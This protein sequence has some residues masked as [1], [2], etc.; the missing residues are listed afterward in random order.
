MHIADI[1]R[2]HTLKIAFALTGGFLMILQ[3]A[4]DAQFF[5][6][7]TSGNRNDITL[8]P[9][10]QSVNIDP[11][12]FTVSEIFHHS[13]P[14]A[15]ITYHGAG[16]T[17]QD[18]HPE[19]YISGWS[20]R[21]WN[22]DPPPPPSELTIFEANADDTVV[23]SP[24]L[25]G[26]TTTPGTTF[27]RVDDFDGDT[28]PD[29]LITGHNESPFA[30]TPNTIYLNR[31]DH[32]EPRNI[33]PAMAMHEG[34]LGDFDLDGD[35][36][37][38]ASAYWVDLVFS[39]GPSSAQSTTNDQA[40][41]V[42]FLNDGMS[43]FTAWPL[44]F[45]Q[46]IEGLDADRL[47][48]LEKMNSGSAAAFGNID[49][50][51]ENEIIVID[52]NLGPGGSGQPE[53]WIIDDI[54]FESRYIYGTFRPLPLPYLETNSRFANNPFIGVTVNPSHDVHVELLDID[55]DG[56]SDLVIDS[57]IWTEHP[58]DTAGVVQFL[59]NDGTGSFTDVTETTLYNYNLMNWGSHD[60]R[61]L[62]VNHDGFIDILKV[63]RG[64][65]ETV[66]K[67]W[68][69]GATMGS[70]QSAPNTWAND[71][72]INTGTGK[73]VSA[74]RD[75]FHILT[76]RQEQIFK[77]YGNE[78]IPY[79]L[80]DYPYYPYLLRD[81]RLG[82]ATFQEV[83]P[84]RRAITGDPPEQFWFDVRSKH[85]LSTGPYGQNTSSQG[86]PGYSEYFYLTE[87]PDVMTSIETGYYSTGLEHY[88][89]QGHAE[90]RKTFAPGAHVH[91][92]NDTDVIT[93][94]EG[95]EQ[96]FGYGGSDVFTGLAG[97]DLLDGGTGFDT[98]MFLGPRNNYDLQIEGGTLTVTALDTNEGT[99]TL[100]SIE[101]LRFTDAVICLH[102]TP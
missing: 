43:N 30:M 80:F 26:T 94:R 25:L 89:R 7:G 67:Q 6:E 8:N 68:P 100:K 66:T 49:T 65:M 71:I 40:A 70:L 93:L 83:T 45:N 62:D 42:L 48:G 59:E 34:Y 101:Y 10:P 16:D 74:F 15:V 31:G 1:L 86:A 35:V 53:S 32:F 5:R 95:D 85:L 54:A 60:P 44:R 3:T 20:W 23:L 28:R 12:F 4:N 72:L 58:Q 90:G 19:L 75:G 57:L 2:G 17:D 63:Q 11:D 33:S 50:D 91:G 21:G 55:N 84:L 78:F 79:S 73:F 92:H 56:D 64:V 99:D 88:Q 9:M 39:E 47:V 61:H 18:G 38:I 102:C 82:F 51:P 52:N 13:V 22:A 69:G 81:G 87:Y 29:V 96:A 37:F 46:A 98:A 76:L 36:D 14:N 24:E 27:L 77:T 97:N 41:L